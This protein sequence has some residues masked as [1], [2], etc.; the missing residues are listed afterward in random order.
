MDVGRSTS[1]RSSCAVSSELPEPILPVPSPER[2]GRRALPET[3]PGVQDDRGPDRDRRQP[4][5]QCEA[6]TEDGGWR[7]QREA[8]D[9]ST[10]ASLG[11]PHPSHGLERADPHER[12]AQQGEPPMAEPLE[13][14]SERPEPPGVIGS[15]P[16]RAR[17]AS[18]MGIEPPKP[19][20]SRISDAP[21]AVAVQGMGRALIVPPFGS[22]GWATCP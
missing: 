21:A 4:E 20:A 7:R 10:S 15:S 3:T 6:E 8:E 22:A 1:C 5:R 16:R 13:R 2:P 11:E 9:P 17:C 19:T 12:G 18:A 14:T